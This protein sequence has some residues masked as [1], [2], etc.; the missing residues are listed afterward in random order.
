MVPASD[1]LL[2][3]SSILRLGSVCRLTIFTMDAKDK[4]THV[5]SVL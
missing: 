2:V 4:K 3:L 1:V 5:P